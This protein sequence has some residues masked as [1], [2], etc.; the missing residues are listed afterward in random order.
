MVREH[1]SV[2]D[3]TKVAMRGRFTQLP[4][5][6]CASLNATRSLAQEIDRKLAEYREKTGEEMPAEL[7]STVLHGAM[8][9]DMARDAVL[10]GVGMSNYTKIKSYVEERYLE[11]QER[12]IDVGTKKD[13][14]LD[15]FD[16]GEEEWP[17]D[18]NSLNALKGGKKGWGKGK[19]TEVKG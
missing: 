6:R 13:K 4:G 17:D 14:A 8:D 19:G 12:K 18:E 3:N 10:A 7:Q 1:D 11:Q 9:D 15:S 16:D 2:T 5:N